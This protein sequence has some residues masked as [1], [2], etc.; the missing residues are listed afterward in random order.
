LRA[1]PLPTRD[2]GPSIASFGDC[3]RRVRD[4]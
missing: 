4:F 1:A 2:S 3:N